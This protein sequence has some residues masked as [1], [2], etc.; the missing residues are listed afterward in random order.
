[1]KLMTESDHDNT[2]PGAAE[3]EPPDAPAP[4]EYEQSGLYPA[5]G[6]PFRLWAL[7]GWLSLLIVVLAG[8]SALLNILLLD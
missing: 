2:E 1:M 3:P 6:K 4:R 5:Q 7:L 8:V